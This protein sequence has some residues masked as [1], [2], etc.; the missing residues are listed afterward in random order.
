[1]DFPVHT[2]VTLYDKRQLYSVYTDWVRIH[3][4]RY[5]SEYNNTRYNDY[6]DKEPDILTILCKGLHS[7]EDNS[8]LCLC[9]SLT[10]DKLIL[11]KEAALSYNTFSKEIYAV[12]KASQLYNIFAILQKNLPDVED[13]QLQ[14]AAKA[15]YKAN[16][17][18]I[19]TL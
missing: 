2:I 1:M 6:F 10:T 8:M 15:L 3:A 5:L 12:L 13:T 11:V 17:V 18:R 4:E 16:L 7:T 14:D 9:R 19:N